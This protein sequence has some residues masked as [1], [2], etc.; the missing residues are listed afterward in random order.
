MKAIV[1]LFGLLKSGKVLTTSGSMLVSLW[2]YALSFGWK[3]A[4]GFL[5]LLFAHEMGHYVAAR[6]RGLDVGAPT[7]IPFVGAWIEMKEMPHDAETEAYVGF[8]GPF[9]GT[10]AALVCYWAA[11]ATDSSIVLAIAYSGFMLNL[12]NLIPISPLDGGRIT[13]VLSPRVWLFGVPVLIAWFFWRPSPMLLVVVVLAIPQL[14]KAVKYRADAQDAFY[15][16]VSTESKLTYAIY[17]LGL[18]GFC[19]TMSFELHNI[20]SRPS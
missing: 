8:G 13:A 15:Y 14:V 19:A 17:Y 2:V 10:L 12:F 4:A 11:R 6:Q 20:L 18:T 16:R 5:A 1:L 7:F 9:V 3:F